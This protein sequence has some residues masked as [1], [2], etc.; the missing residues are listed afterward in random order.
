MLLTPRAPSPAAEGALWLW[1]IGGRHQLPAKLLDPAV[2]LTCGK[3]VQALTDEPPICDRA[4]VGDTVEHERPTHPV[5][6]RVPIEHDPVALAGLAH[7]A[8]VGRVEGLQ[9]V[10]EVVAEVVFP[11]EPGDVGVHRRTETGFLIE[12]CHC[13]GSPFDATCPLSCC[14][15]G[16]CGYA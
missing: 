12:A 4:D 2:R 10:A 3:D 8:V 16:R 9:L 5:A 7:H 14:Q 13:R 11:V 15:G 6:G 1:V